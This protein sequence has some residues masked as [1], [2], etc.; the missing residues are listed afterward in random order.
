MKNTGLICIVWTTF[1]KPVTTFGK[2]PTNFGK[3]LSMFGKPLTMFGKPLKL[4]FCQY[5]YMRK[6]PLG[7]KLK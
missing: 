4:F 7:W 3:P 5:D 2:P 6:T 1:G